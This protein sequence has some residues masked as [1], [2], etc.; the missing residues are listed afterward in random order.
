MAIGIGR[1]QIPGIGIGAQTLTALIYW[2]VPYVPNYLLTNEWERR[3][4]FRKCW[5]PISRCINHKLGR[6]VEMCVATTF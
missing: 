4:S 3:N 6:L 5:L 2:S 1:L